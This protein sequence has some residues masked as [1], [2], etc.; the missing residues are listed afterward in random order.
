MMVPTL[1]R[2]SSLQRLRAAVTQPDA[3]PQQHAPLPCGAAGLRDRPLPAADFDPRAEA[4]RQH[5]RPPDRLDR[6]LSERLAPVAVFLA[7]LVILV[8][9]I[10]PAH[11]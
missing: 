2:R 11:L 4:H 6:T 1:R 9:V 5:L 8:A 10:G 7:V 3:A